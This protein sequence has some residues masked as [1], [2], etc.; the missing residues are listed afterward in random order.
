MRHLSC[1]ML[2]CLLFL[3]VLV[4]PAGADEVSLLNKARRIAGYLPLINAQDKDT[5]QWNSLADENIKY[6]GSTRCEPGAWFRMKHGFPEQISSQEDMNRRVYAMAYGLLE[7][8]LLRVAPGITHA[9]LWEWLRRSNTS[10]YGIASLEFD[11]EQL[12]LHMSYSPE[13]RILAAFRNHDLHRFLN[14]KEKKVLQTC[15]WWITE[16]ISLGMPNAQKLHRVHDALADTTSP[17][18]G[19]CSVACSFWYA[20]AC[21]WHHRWKGRIPHTLTVC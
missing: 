10:I 2:C 3:L 12:W 18:P 5:P 4:N 1:Q 14:K 13:A 17:L 15:A 7:K 16:N 19:G 6:A 11:G 21:W 20:F 9:K 8:E